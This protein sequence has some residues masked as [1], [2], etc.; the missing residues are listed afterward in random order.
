LEKGLQADSE[1]NMNLDSDT[2]L[3]R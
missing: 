1:I 3:E 2:E